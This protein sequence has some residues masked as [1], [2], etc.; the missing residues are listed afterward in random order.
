MDGAAHK[1]HWLATSA[2]P[3]AC[4]RHGIP[5]TIAA[6]LHV[7]NTTEGPL[8]KAR[9]EFHNITPSPYINRF[10]MRPERCSFVSFPDV[11]CLNRLREIQS[12]TNAAACRMIT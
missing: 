9:I 2:I 11:S 7:G 10:L 8:S 4:S 3:R 1:Q 6:L 5:L 12:T